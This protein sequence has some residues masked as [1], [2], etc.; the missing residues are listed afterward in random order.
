MAQGHVRLRR[1]WARSDRH[2]QRWH[3]ETD[4]HL[5]TTAPMMLGSS[6][7]A[8]S[9]CCDPLNKWLTNVSVLGD[10]DEDDLKRKYPS[11]T[12]YVGQA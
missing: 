11:E 9:T 6:F 7:S 5:D 12:L 10:E 2:F 1:P 4:G 8:T 3:E